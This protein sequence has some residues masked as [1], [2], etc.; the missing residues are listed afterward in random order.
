MV[1]MEMGILVGACVLG[2][3]EA[4]SAL[5]KQLAWAGLELGLGLGNLGLVKK[6]EL[7]KKMNNLRAHVKLNGNKVVVEF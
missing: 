5:G 7:I 6:L 3:G 2:F 4:I 1:K